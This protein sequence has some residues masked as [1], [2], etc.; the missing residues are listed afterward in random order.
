M[1]HAKIKST[2][3]DSPAGRFGPSRAEGH[4]SARGDDEMGIGPGQLPWQTLFHLMS[5]AGEMDHKGLSRSRGQTGGP[6]DS[7]QVIAS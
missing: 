4:F 7:E 5:R 6:K 2:R 3:I 1:A